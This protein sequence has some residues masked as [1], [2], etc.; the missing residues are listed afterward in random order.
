[1]NTTE[2]EHKLKTMTEERD[3][4]VFNANQLQKQVNGWESER[5]ELKRR[6]TELE[7]QLVKLLSC[8]NS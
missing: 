2:L 6:I 4:W 8:G 5:S 7:S 3:A 1:M